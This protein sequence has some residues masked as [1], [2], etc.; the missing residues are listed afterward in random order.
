MSFF[1]YFCKRFQRTGDL[2]HANMHVAYMTNLNL[3]R[4]QSRIYAIKL[5]QPAIFF[6]SMDISENKIHRKIEGVNAVFQ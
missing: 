5:D 3:T 4:L 6:N 1:S 2:Q